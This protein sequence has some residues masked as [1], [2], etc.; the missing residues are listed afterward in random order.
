VERT[1]VVALDLKTGNTTLLMSGGDPVAQVEGPPTLDAKGTLL[2]TTA[3]GE[4][5]GIDAQGVLVRRTALEAMPALFGADAGALPPIFRR[6]E[7]RS[8]PPLV[9]DGEGKVAFLRSSGKLGIID[10]TGNVVTANP[11][12]CARPLAVLPAGPERM[13][14]TCRSGSVTMYGNSP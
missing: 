13:L 3:L 9:V 6:L 10:A 8:S 5:L 2:V 14:V 1:R 12:L 7:S 11:R 4:L